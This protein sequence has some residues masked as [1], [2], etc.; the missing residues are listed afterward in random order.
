[1]LLEMPL[2]KLMLYWCSP[3]QKYIVN[4]QFHRVF[5]HKFWQENKKLYL[6]FSLNKL[7]QEIWLSGVTRSKTNDFK[8]YA[9]ITLGNPWQPIPSFFKPL[10]IGKNFELLCVSFFIIF[11]VSL[12][13]SYYST[14]SVTCKANSFPCVLNLF[15]FYVLLK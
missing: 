2:N 14:H 8:I 9:K 4:V 12:K 10:K 13:I 3:K 15:R 7:L 6:L 1:M 11:R 5:D